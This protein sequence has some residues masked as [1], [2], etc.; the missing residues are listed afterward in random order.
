MYV[1]RVVSWHFQVNTH[2][3]TLQTRPSIS[4]P[5]VE[6][7][8]WCNF[9]ISCE[10]QWCGMSA[11]KWRLSEVAGGKLLLLLLRAHQFLSSSLFQTVISCLLCPGEADCLLPGSSGAFWP[12]LSSS[13]NGNKWNWRDFYKDSYLQKKLPHQH[14]SLKSRNQT[15]ETILKNWI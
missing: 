1:R 15:G 8:G 10:S 5:F 2:Y 9:M 14:Q 13:V 12:T 7:P 4:S 11:A 6:A 3:F